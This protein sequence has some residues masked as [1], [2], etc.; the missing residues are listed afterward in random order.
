VCSYLKWKG[1]EHAIP[2]F[3]SFLKGV[4]SLQKVETNILDFE[5]AKSIQS[6]HSFSG[7]MWD[8]IIIAAQMKR[9]N[10][11]EIYSNDKD[12]DKMR[13]IERIF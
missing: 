12:F 10:V 8:D 1:K 13:W 6:Q 9:L 5:E 7:S 3:L 2:P 4:T 11:K